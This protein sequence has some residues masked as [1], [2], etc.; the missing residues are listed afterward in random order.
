MRI[1]YEWT[2]REWDQAVELA[3]RKAARRGRL[4]GMVYALVGIPLLGAVGDLISLVRAPGKISLAGSIVP[5]LLMIFAVTAAVLIGVSRRRRLRRR[6]G[7]SAMPHGVQEMVLRESGWRF[8]AVEPQTVATASLRAYTEV[9][10]ARQADGVIVLVHHAGFEAVPARA[11][12]PEQAGHL[13]RMVMRK[14]RSAG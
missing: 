8:G 12:T 6:D 7:V 10:E 2:T 4:P 11:L 5:L 3:M 13:H 14:M 9:V 1:T